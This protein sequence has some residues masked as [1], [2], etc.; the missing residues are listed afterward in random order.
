MLTVF[1][2][3]KRFDVICLFPLSVCL[4]R[5]AHKFSFVGLDQLTSGGAVQ[6]FV[7]SVLDEPTILCL[8]CVLTVVTSQGDDLLRAVVDCP[9]ERLLRT[10]PIRRRFVPYAK[11]EFGDEDEITLSLSLLWN[12]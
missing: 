6:A 3:S 1:A 9:K 10:S 11:A 2:A 7:Y 4:R 8:L 5:S 12:R